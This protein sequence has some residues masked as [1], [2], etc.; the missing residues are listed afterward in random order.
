[1]QPISRAAVL[2]AVA[3]CG[4]LGRPAFLRRYG[5]QEAREYF[6]IHRGKY[7]DSKAIVGVAHAYDPKVGRALQPQEFS[8]GDTTVRRLLERLGF[9]VVHNP[10]GRNPTRAPIILVQNEVTVGGKYDFWADETGV[11]YQF[12][13]RYK[14]RI[15]P[16]RPFLYYRGVRRA[17]GKRSQAEYFGF[18]EIGEVWRDPDQARDTQPSRRRWYCSIEDYAPFPEPVPSRDES[19]AFFEQIGSQ[20]GWRTAVREIDPATYDRILARAGFNAERLDATPPGGWD[21][22]PAELVAVD[23]NEL[24]PPRAKV[25]DAGKGVD[26]PRRTRN[27]KWIGD[28]AEAAVRRWLVTTLEP[29]EA[30]SVIWHA[31]R[32][33]TPGYDLSYTAGDG[34]AVGCEVKG[35]TGK[36]FGSVELTG[37]EWRAASELRDR[38]WLLL[39]TGVG[40]PSPRVAVIPDPVGRSEA[41]RLEATVTSVRIIARE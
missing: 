41:G 7:Y 27:A 36:R 37:N 25:A 29:E 11:R 34:K 23:V 5:Y 30:E 33:E 14:N 3:E 35:T 16:G 21:A 17:S 22:P 24:L 12:P 4:R 40:T 1:M 32:G 19:G 10:K 18:G 13:N 8:G 31:Q 2:A 15:R 39:V 9:A 20:L 38:F 6:L 28:E 26:G